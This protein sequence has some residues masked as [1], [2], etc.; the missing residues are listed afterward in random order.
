MERKVESRNSPVVL[1]ILFVALPLLMAAG[2]AA[3]AFIIDLTP[4]HASVGVGRSGISGFVIGLA[5]GGLSVLHMRRHSRK[6]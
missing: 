3:V 6:G 2:F 5:I 1:A 4:L